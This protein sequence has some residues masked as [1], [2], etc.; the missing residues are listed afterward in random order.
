MSHGLKLI[1]INDRDNNFLPVLSSNF[2]HF[3]VHWDLNQKQQCIWTDLNS[4]INFFNVNVGVWEPFVE[5][6][7]VKVMV[8]EEISAQNKNLQCN[9]NTPLN[10]NFTEKLVENLHESQNSW[11]IVENNFKDFYEKHQ[12]LEQFKDQNLNVDLLRN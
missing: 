12:L 6:F 3:T 11:R 5:P 4:S 8:N 9:I 10:I 2:S 7:N 1:L